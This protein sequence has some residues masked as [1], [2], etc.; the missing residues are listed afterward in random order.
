MLY[1]RMNEKVYM[2]DLDSK[3]PFIF[4]N[5]L[6]IIVRLNA[7]PGS[8]WSLLFLLVF[9]LFQYLIWYFNKEK[10]FD[11]D[12]LALIKEMRKNDTHDCMEDL[13]FQIYNK[14]EK[15]KNKNKKC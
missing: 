7:R 13:R 6:S 4:R 14:L 8:S 11:Y 9:L 10:H 3:G 1:D 2:K 12:N 15:F 5:M